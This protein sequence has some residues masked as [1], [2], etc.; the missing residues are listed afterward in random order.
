MGVISTLDG[1]RP[2]TKIDRGSWWRCSGESVDQPD[3]AR[4]Y[5]LHPVRGMNTSSR[6]VCWNNASARSYSVA[7]GTLL[8]GRARIHAGVA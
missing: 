7:R 5:A 2:Q 3:P 8:A 6:C 4:N 1:V